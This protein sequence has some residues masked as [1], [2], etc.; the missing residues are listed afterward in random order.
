MPPNSTPFELAYAD[1]IE[2]ATAID[3]PIRD[4]WSPD[5]CPVELL[6]WLAWSL[7]VDQWDRDW[8]ESVK[9]RVIRESLAIHRIKGSRASVERALATLGLADAVITEGFDAERHDGAHLRDG[10]ITY[11]RDVHWATYRVFLNTPITNKQ[12][13]LVR[14]ALATVAPARSHL[15]QLDFTEAVALHDGTITRDGTF[16]YGVA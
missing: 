12:A 4:L 15:D 2:N 11:G 16:N 13:A 3:V 6:P 14:D 10:S 7:S 9:R 1:A 8:P 5:R